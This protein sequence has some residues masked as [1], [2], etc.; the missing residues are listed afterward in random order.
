MVLCDFFWRI[1]L[2]LR[3]SG[4]LLLDCSIWQLGIWTIRGAIEIKKSSKTSVLN[5]IYYS[6]VLFVSCFVF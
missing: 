6:T 4:G 1:E 3:R 5:G 2:E